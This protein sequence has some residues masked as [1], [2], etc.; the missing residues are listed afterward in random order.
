MIGTD[1][2]PAVVNG[3]QTFDGFIESATDRELLELI[4]RQNK[5]LIEQF[6]QVAS[7]FGDIHQKVSEGGI[8]GLMKGLMGRG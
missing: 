1:N 8:A 2:E 6:S 3:E 7:M 4:A 5:T